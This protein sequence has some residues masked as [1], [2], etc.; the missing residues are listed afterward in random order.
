[1]ECPNLNP[2]NALTRMHR[3]KDRHLNIDECTVE[4]AIN[5][6]SLDNQYGYL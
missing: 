1:V 4:G 6:E 2:W 3:K 5:R